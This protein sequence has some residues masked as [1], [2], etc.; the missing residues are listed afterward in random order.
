M[1][2]LL[3]VRSVVDLLHIMRS[4]ARFMALR[5]RGLL[6]LYLAVSPWLGKVSQDAAGAFDQWFFDEVSEATWERAIEQRFGLRSGGR[7]AR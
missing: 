5:D 2:A 4:P 3:V 1:T 6:R 7:D